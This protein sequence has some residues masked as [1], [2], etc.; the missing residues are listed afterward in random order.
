MVAKKK[1]TETTWNAGWREIGGIR[2]YYRSRWEANYAR[3]LQF[4]LE[5]GEIAKWEH[6]P[7]TFWFD[8]IKRGTRSYLPDFRVTGLDGSVTYH[9]VKGWMDPRSRTKLKRMKKY[10]P[11][12]KLV[13]VDSKVYK[14]LTKNANVI[15]PGWE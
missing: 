11:H 3:L 8:A 6:E 4:Q 9:E 1:A 14:S 13:V 7:E 10:H 2:K 5:R 12:I 15:I